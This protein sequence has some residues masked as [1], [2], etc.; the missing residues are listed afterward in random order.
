MSILLLFRKEAGARGGLP[1][2]GVKLNTLVQRLQ[3]AYQLT[4]GGKFQEAAVKF[5]DILLHVT[6]LVV[7]SK[8]DISEVR[9]VEILVY[10]HSDS[11]LFFLEVQ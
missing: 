2:V 8:Q 7:D 11:E 4:T 3:I 1:A 6:L 10:N 5:Q 9:L